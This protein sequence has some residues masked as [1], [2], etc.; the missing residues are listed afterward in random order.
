MT[1]EISHFVRC[2]A[3]MISI[4]SSDEVVFLEDSK[5]GAEVDEVV[6]EGEVVEPIDIESS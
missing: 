6:P 5:V 2:G 4:L 3:E 1:S